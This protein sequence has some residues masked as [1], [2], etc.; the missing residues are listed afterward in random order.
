MFLRPH[1]V[2]SRSPVQILPI[3]HKAKESHFLEHH[4]SALAAAQGAAIKHNSLMK[5]NDKKAGE[6][7]ISDDAMHHHSIAAVH[8]ER[9][10]QKL[11]N[12]KEYHSRRIGE[13]KSGHASVDHDE[14]AKIK[15]SKQFSA[16]ADRHADHAERLS[17]GVEAHSEAIRSHNEAR[18]T[19][20]SATRKLSEHAGSLKVRL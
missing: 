2:S 15:A 14:I 8:H 18:K 11:E 17:K 7:H 9:I 3:L 13:I 1:R 20:A 10:L 16:D 19:H 12:N 6:S 4:E 5:Y